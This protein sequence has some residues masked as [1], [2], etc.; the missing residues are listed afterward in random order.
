VTP[1]N[2]SITPFSPFEFDSRK[3]LSSTNSTPYNFAKDKSLFL[4]YSHYVGR[5]DK[6]YLNKYGEFFISK[7]V[8]STSPIVP[9]SIENALEVATITMNPYV[10]NV[11]DVLVQLSP[12]KRYRMKDISKLED[13]IRNI[14]Y[15]TSLSL[16]ETDTKNLTLRD[17]QTQLDRFKCGFLVDNFKSISSGSLGDSQYKCSID[18]KEGILRPQHYTTSIDLLLG[19]EFVIGNSNVSNP[20]VDL[21]FVKELGSPNIVKVGDVICLKYSD[22]VFLKNTFAT[23][24]ENVNPFNVVNWIGA[25]ELNPATDTWIETRGTT[26]TIDREGNYRAT[27]QQLSADTNTGLSP[28]DWGAWETTWTGTREIARENITRLNETTFLGSTNNRGGFES[29][30]RHKS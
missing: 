8:P 30:Q 13:R 3:F 16:L 4:S 29:G 28:V 25:I 18:T 27:I 1:Y 17:S 10:Y 5:I 24:I 2:S 15:Y 6:L 26:R 7:G 22:E 12:H 19:S 21:R 11:G 23:R 9:E 20:D 14:E